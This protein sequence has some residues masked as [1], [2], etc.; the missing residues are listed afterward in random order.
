MLIFYLN[1]LIW[2]NHM[3]IFSLFCLFFVFINLTACHADSSHPPHQAPSHASLYSNTLLLPSDLTAHAYLPLNKTLAKDIR[4]V[5]G[6]I[7]QSGSFL[8]IV[9]PAD[10]LFEPA[11]SVLLVNADQLIGD[12]AQ[13]ISRFPDEGVIITA[14]TDGVGSEYSQA[15]LSSQQAQL[16]AITLW[17]QDNID[18]KSFQ[19]FK[20]A[21]MGGTQPITQDGSA[22]GQALN[23]RLQITIYPLTETD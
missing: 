11:S 8:T 23:R 7:Y 5:G 9:I 6:E 20:Y 13:I 18:L 22:Y 10:A 4:A 17:Q 19:T 1:L 16:F 14:H 15:K 12:V 3:R 2:L 21:G